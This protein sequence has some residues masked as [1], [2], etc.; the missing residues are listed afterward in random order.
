MVVAPVFWIM[1]SPSQ[2]RQTAFRAKAFALGLQ[3][4]VSP[5]P[6]TH[7]AHVRKEMPDQGA[8]Y[9]LEWREKSMPTVKSCLGLNTDEGIEWSGEGNT[10]VQAVLAK[11]LETT[12]L[13]I[14]AIECNQAGV[15]VYWR[16]GGAVD[17]VEGISQLLTDLRADCLKLLG[18]KA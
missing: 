18:V 2:K 12:E 14:R 15:G 10:G 6:Q 11:G 4:R 16:E 7:R 17:N 3:V 1:P 9:K 13:P 8:L 5:I